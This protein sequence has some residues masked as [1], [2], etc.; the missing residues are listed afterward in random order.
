MASRK[1]R[2]N[3]CCTMWCDCSGSSKKV[4]ACSDY[5]VQWQGKKELCR[6]EYQN[7]SNYFFVVCCVV[8]KFLNSASL[9][10]HVSLLSFFLALLKPKEPPR[11]HRK[12]TNSRSYLWAPILVAKAILKDRDKGHR[13]ASIYQWHTCTLCRKNLSC[14]HDTVCVYRKLQTELTNYVST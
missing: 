2:R 5:Y 10:L 14:P 7:H 1:G 9:S 12:R 11:S 13:W 6:E 4:C 8:F 3:Q